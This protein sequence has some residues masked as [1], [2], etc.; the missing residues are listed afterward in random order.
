M[1][2]SCANPVRNH[3]ASAALV[4]SRRS[5][6]L[7]YLKRARGAAHNFIRIFIM[8]GDLAPRGAEFRVHIL[9]QEKFT[10]NNSRKFGVRRFCVLSL[11]I[12]FSL[13]LGAQQDNNSTVSEDVLIHEANYSARI[14]K[15]AFI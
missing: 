2:V 1:Y 12:F 10:M 4:L 6:A 7:T 3:F 11:T 14:S 5:L 8:Y 15:D 13:M 9:K